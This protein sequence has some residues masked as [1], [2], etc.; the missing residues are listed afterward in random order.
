MFHFWVNF[1]KT[2]LAS[3]SR[4]DISATVQ[5]FVEQKTLRLIEQFHEEYPEFSKIALAGG[6]FANVKLNQRIWDS[7][8]FKS[9][10][11]APAMDDAG[12]ALRRY[13]DWETDRKSVV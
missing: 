12:L 4:E 5:H 10:F 3:L 11:V 1:F 7:G 6:L 9:L 8:L 13:R 2:Q